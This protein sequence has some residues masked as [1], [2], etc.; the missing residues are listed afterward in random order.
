LVPLKPKLLESTCRSGT[1]GGYRRQVA[2]YRVGR[3]DVDGT[4]DEAALQYQQ[5][6][7]RFLHAG[8][9]LRMAGQ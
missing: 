1:G 6:I 8:G 2:Y 9:T 4:G 5:A 7:D 3:F